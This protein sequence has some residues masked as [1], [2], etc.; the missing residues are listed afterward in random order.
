MPVD[1]KT[2]ICVIGGGPAGATVARRLTRLGHQVLLVE[3]HP[4]PR[5][6][7]GE[8]LSPG[9]LPLLDVL[10]VRDCIESADFFRPQ[11]ALIRWRNKLEYVHWEP[12]E[13]GFQVDRGVFDLLLLNLAAQSGVKLVQP[14]RA[15]ST[16]ADPTG[17]WLVAIEHRGRLRQAKAEFIIDASGKHSRMPPKRRRTSPPTLALYGYWRETGIDGCE[18]RVEA[19]ERCWFWGAPLPQRTLNAAVFLDARLCKIAGSDGVECLYRGLLSESTLLR[20]CLNGKLVNRVI[21]CDASSY[22][23][24]AP[25]GTSFIKVGEACFAIDPLSSQGV[26]A[27]MQSALQ[28]SIVC[29][30]ILNTPANTSAAMQFYRVRQAQA[31]EQHGRWAARYYA[32]QNS[33]RPHEFWAARAEGAWQARPLPEPSRTRPSEECC[34]E[35]SKDAIIVETAVIRRDVV[36]LSP[37]ITHP[38]LDRPVAFV[39]E[40]AVAPLLQAVVS[41]QTVKDTLHQWSQSVPA[42]AALQILHWMVSRRIIVPVTSAAGV[43]TNGIGE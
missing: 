24:D 29:H 37:A 20:R 25:V 43:N 35:R 31:V 40:I 11:R 38:E 9:I 7:V 19:G 13:P 39:G 28:A 32:E 26:Q 18:S 30:T 3:Q 34:I 33:F 4:F 23:T 14:G 6:H 8:S 27:A 21:A 17:G 10:E 36:E 2:E 41:G 5:S 22:R 1:W 16:V 12:H 15:L 42:A